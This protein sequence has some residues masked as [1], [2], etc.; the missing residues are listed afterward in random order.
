MKAMRRWSKWGQVLGVAGRWSVLALAAFYLNF[1]SAHLA[2]ETHFHGQVEEHSHAQANSHTHVDAGHEGEHN[3]DHEDEGG[4]GHTPHDA[5][6]HLLDVAVKG[7]DPAIPGPTLAIALE[8]FVFDAPVLFSWAQ[9]LF[10]RERPPGVSPPD[11][12]QPRAPPLA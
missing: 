5:S 7:A 10:E 1:V 8:T 4:R 6:E 3:H 11:P 9:P 12:L 2:T